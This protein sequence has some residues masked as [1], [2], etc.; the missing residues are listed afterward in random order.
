MGRPV[1][2]VENKSSRFL[3]RLFLN[4]LS[5]M[6]SNNFLGN[7]GVGEREGRIASTLVLY[8]YLLPIRLQ[9]VISILL[10]EL[11][12]RAMWPLSK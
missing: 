1:H 10:M 11:G 5:L 8:D 3:S 4:D 2:R 6:D 12:E 9:S 7:S